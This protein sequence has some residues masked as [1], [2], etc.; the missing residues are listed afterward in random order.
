MKTVKLLLAFIFFAALSGSSCSSSSNPTPTITD[1]KCE[2]PFKD[3]K[4]TRNALAGQWNWIQTTQTGRGGT[5]ITTPASAGETREINFTSDTNVS[6]LTNGKTTGTYSYLVE[7]SP[8]AEFY[9]TMFNADGSLY[10]TFQIFGCNQS[11]RLI[12]LSSS[13]AAESLYNKK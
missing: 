2:N 1:P 6:F 13:L 5:V 7:S 9:L 12:D 11:F 10:K 4:S 8:T 3:A